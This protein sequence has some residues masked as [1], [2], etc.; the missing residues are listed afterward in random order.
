MGG[1]E[2]RKDEGVRYPT[3]YQRELAAVRRLEADI[4]RI[5]REIEDTEAKNADL[6]AW[7]RQWDEVCREFGLDPNSFRFPEAGGQGSGRQQGQ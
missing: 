6:I 2:D 1:Q 3:R 5:H 7:H 4:Q